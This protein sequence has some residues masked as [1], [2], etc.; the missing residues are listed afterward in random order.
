M[1]VWATF[2]GY[3][4]CIQSSHIQN[5]Y[6]D[7][8]W[9]CDLYQTEGQARLALMEFAEGRPFDNPTGNKITRYYKPGPTIFE[10]GEETSC[11]TKDGHCE[12]MRMAEINV[13]GA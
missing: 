11:L 4:G 10:H 2:R 1:K 7:D 13:K 12:W 8:E 5:K 9:L 6:N 3:S